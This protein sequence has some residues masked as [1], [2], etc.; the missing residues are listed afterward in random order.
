MWRLPWVAFGLAFLLTWLLTPLVKTWARRCGAVAVP[1][2]RD[3]HKEPI[4]RWGGLAMLGAFLLTLAAVYGWSVERNVQMHLPPP[5]SGFLIH[6]FIGLVLALLIIG[7]AGAIDDRW[8][9]SA[10]FQIAALIA[11][12]WIVAFFGVRISGITNPM[13]GSQYGSPGSHGYDPRSWVQFSTPVSYCATILWVFGVA[14]TMDFIDGL[15]G[16]AAGVSGICALTLAFMSAQNQ[17]YEVTIF[18]AALV[19]VCTAFLRYNFNPASIFMGTAGAQMLGFALAA[20]AIVGTFKIAATVSVA[21]PIIVLLVP[22]GDGVR[23]VL[24]RA[25]RGQKPHIADNTSHVHHILINQMGL[26][27]KSAVLVLYSITAGCCLIALVLLKVV[28]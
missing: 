7:I 2:D 23:V 3:I 20:I 9:T 27:Q 25:L 8:E 13:Y 16:L 26:S 18:A 14:K 21:L 17:Q 5:W 12:G 19:G 4:P 6:E 24:T 15:D 28:H 10:V 1:R 22:V 11:A